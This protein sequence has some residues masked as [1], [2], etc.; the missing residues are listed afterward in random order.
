MNLYPL[1]FSAVTKING[2]SMTANGS[3]PYAENIDN[4]RYE[5][6]H[7]TPFQN[8]SHYESKGYISMYIGVGI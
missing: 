3:F 4:E 1:S 5:Q 2:F 8:K 6:P 7:R